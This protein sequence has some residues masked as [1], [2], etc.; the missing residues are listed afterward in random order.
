M[1]KWTFLVLPLWLMASHTYSQGD[2]YFEQW[3]L[4]EGLSNQVIR[5]IAQDSHGFLWLATEQG[6]NRFD[7]QNFSHYLHV[8]GD[9]NS[10]TNNLLFGLAIDQQDVIWVGTELGLN[11]Y[12]LKLN[13]W[14][15]FR[16]DP[17]DP[18][19]LSDNYVRKVFVDSQDRIWVG[20]QNG[21]NLFDRT[22]GQFQR[23]MDD[24]QFADAFDRK[25]FSYNRINDVYEDNEGRIWVGTDGGGIRIY[26]PDSW[27]KFTSIYVRDNLESRARIVRKVFQ[28]AIGDWWF[29][30]DAGLARYSSDLT[31]QTFFEPHDAFD[32]LSDQ[33]VWDMLEGP[34]G[35]LWVSTY[36]GGINVL[37]RNQNRFIKHFD[38]SN[39]LSSDQVWDMF[40]DHS[41]GIWVGCE[42]AGGL[43]YY[44]PA[45]RKFAHHL[46]E[47]GTKF[48]V[49]NI[50]ESTPQLLLL[51]TSE[52]LLHYHVPDR[53]YQCITEKVAN[54]SEYFFFEQHNNRTYLMSSRSIYRLD[55]KF[56]LIQKFHSKLLINGAI[57]TDTYMADSGEIW[58]GTI[59]QGLLRVNLITGEEE[60]F[61]KEGNS[62][63]YQ[64]S[65]SITSLAAGP[66]GKLWVASVRSGLFLLDPSNGEYEQFLY[67]TGQFYEPT[68]TAIVSAPDSILW[69]GTVSNG[70]VRFNWETTESKFVSSKNKELS[71]GITAL[72]ID[73]QQK[74]WISTKNGLVTMD[75]ASQ[76]F[77]IFNQE[78]GLQGPLFRPAI[79]QGTSG[80]LYFGGTN[81]FNVLDV[82]HLTFNDEQPGIF[83]E[84]LMVN[85]QLIQPGGKWL[86]DGLEH[87]TRIRL[88]YDQNYLKLNFTAPTAIQ[89]D[90]NAFAYRLSEDQPWQDLNQNRELSLPNLTAGFYELAIKARNSDGLWGKPS[91]L[92]ID[93]LPPFWQT[94]WFRSTI[95]LIVIFLLVGFYRYRLRQ[96]S[97]QKQ[98]LEQEVSDRTSELKLQKE[99]AEEDREL[100]ASQAEELKE[101]DKVK[102]KFF[103]NISHELR[104]PLT[105]INGPLETFLER[106]GETLNQEALTLIKT[107]N[108]NGESLLGLVEEIL[109][110]TKLEAGKLPLIENPLP[111]KELLTDLF[112]AYHYD[113]KVKGVIA[114]FDFEL[115][116][117][118]CLYL[119]GRKVKK[120]I[121]NLLSNARKFTQPGDK[122]SLR[123]TKEEGWLKVAVKDTGRGIDPTDVPHI[124]DRFYQSKKDGKAEGGTGIGLALS[125][126]LSKLMNGSLH[127]MSELGT[128]SEFVLKL[129]FKPAELQLI[130]ELETDA[131]ADLNQALRQVVINYS[132]FFN[133]DQPTLL[134]AEDN[135]AMRRF[136]ANVFE[137]Q[138]RI[139]EAQDGRHALKYLDKERV[140][141]MISDVMMP[142]MDGFELLNALK[143]NVEW[144]G[145]SVIM[146]TAR[147]AEED[148]LFALTKGVDDYLTKP[149]N[150]AELLARVKNILENRVA[151]HETD[152]IGNLNSKALN[153]DQKFL[154]SLQDLIEKNLDNQLLSVPYLSDE[155]ALSPR[156]LQ[157]KVKEITGLSPL[158]FIKEIRLQKAYRFLA[159]RE[160]PSVADAARKVGFEKTDY[161]SSQ[162]IA[163]FGKRPS[164]M[165]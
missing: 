100:I 71:Q 67:H 22:T 28:D 163:R 124:F 88:P 23:L 162:F 139:L 103:A 69:L 142:G 52:G 133:I 161:F 66:D 40:K 118:T 63:I 165:L 114:E 76:Q 91:I 75:L 15:H 44:H 104:T 21:L 27:D 101:M 6:L 121:N 149:F 108:Q 155:V 159:N 30:T 68:I 110:L 87:Q 120:V 98:L 131:G 48:I 9:T 90:N 116:E 57:I 95:F 82:E 16:N 151:R 109:D 137:G 154:V 31:L 81:G 34:D 119:D 156:Q 3:H 43:N 85:D 102:T 36:R 70:L 160:V 150:K 78:D 136:I 79:H 13:Q 55:E 127:V 157:R 106:E 148:K 152:A 89:A 138:F 153:I 60:Q 164:S 105:L 107:A 147:A 123:A 35:H 111:M 117:D 7:G 20:T 39:G 12:D 8:P 126:E 49:D 93:I 62:D 37:D 158:G 112:D 41:G 84:S 135:T 140:D 5:N 77:H 10:I 86:P 29:G 19:S 18:N 56:N 115:P 25:T 26:E 51:S 17:D 72:L 61:F 1:K 50:F 24:R 2:F 47:D 92:N 38:S 58:M 46:S 11:A 132:E 53:T 65:R 83:F 129:P 33:Y 145:L 99:K 97:R 146:L 141:L 4:E 128:G 113:L 42:G 45:L 59:S 32:S 130:D 144:R 80:K 73:E 143:A 134:L 74:L 125:M 96:I 94:V 122:I 54:E 14:H 64:D